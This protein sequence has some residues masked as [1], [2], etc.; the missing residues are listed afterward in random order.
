[1]RRKQ[2]K[3]TMGDQSDLL[4]LCRRADDHCP[5]SVVAFPPHMEV[6][7]DAAALASVP[8]LKVDDLRLGRGWL[9]RLD[10]KHR[11]QG[12]GIR[13]LSLLAV[14]LGVTL[15]L[16]PEQA[17]A[18]QNS[19]LTGSGVAS[20]SSWVAGALAGYNWQQ[21]SLV[22]G[23]ETDLQRTHLT[24]SMNPG[25][26]HNY[27]VTLRDGA[28]TRSSI[29]W[30]GTVRGRVG[31]TVGSALLYLTGGL[32]YGRVGLNSSLIGFDDGF[33][34]AT[35]SA[36][37]QALR[38]GGVVGAGF[39]YLVG[40]NVMLTFQYQYIDLGRVTVASMATP[41]CCAGEINQSATTHAQIQAAMLGLSYR[42]A[43]DGSK[44]PWTGGYAGIHAGGAFGNEARATYNGWLTPT[45]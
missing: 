42:F 41:L 32:A 37:T 31:T 2:T 26:Q 1:M 38:F 11:N 3:R 22:Y 8:H 24:A 27:N 33:S 16:V 4:T 9:L 6:L 45:P 23:V 21:G 39:E 17:S 15:S 34:P 7:V 12:M 40:P 19:T 43:P 29:D 18:Q 44:L 10:A 13:P 35:T 14:V 28:S 20:A 36:Q 5:S 25:L 30:Y